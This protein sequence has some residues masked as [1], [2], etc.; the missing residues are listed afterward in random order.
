MKDICKM[1]RRKPTGLNLA[2]FE[3]LICNHLQLQI[4]TAFGLSRYLAESQQDLNQQS[5]N[6]T[7]EGESEIFILGS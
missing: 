4:P 2:D 7:I 3:I 5:F 1:P 6:L